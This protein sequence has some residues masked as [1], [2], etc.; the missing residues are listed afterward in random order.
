MLRRELDSLKVKHKDMIA[1]LKTYKDKVTVLRWFRIGTA[2]NS[3]EHEHKNVNSRNEEG[4][5]SL[6]Y[7]VYLLLYLRVTLPIVIAF[8]VVYSGM[9]TQPKMMYH[10]SPRFMLIVRIWRSELILSHHCVEWYIKIDVPLYTS[11]HRSH[12]VMWSVF[13]PK[14]SFGRK[15]KLSHWLIKV[16]WSIFLPK[17][18]F[19]REI[20]QF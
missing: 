14:I 10:D 18:Q 2:E 7:A 3:Y 6:L 16:I 17:L 5:G 1:E 15:F 20:D 9:Y 8:R 13:L 11:V 19:W 12:F 4:K